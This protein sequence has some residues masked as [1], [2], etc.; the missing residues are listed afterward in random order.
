MRCDWCDTNHDGRTLK[1]IGTRSEAN[2]LEWNKVCRN[3]YEQE[4]G[5]RDIDLKI[6][7]KLMRTRPELSENERDREVYKITFDISK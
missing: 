7:E 2:D 6:Y 4:M 1:Q 3:C 5:N